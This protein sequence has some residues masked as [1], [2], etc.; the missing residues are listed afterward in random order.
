M[1]LDQL[2]LRKEELPIL[3]KPDC[4]RFTVPI[5][6]ALLRPDVRIDP[7]IAYHV[8]RQA[9]QEYHTELTQYVATMQ[10]EKEKVW[11]K[12]V[13]LK[14]PTVMTDKRG[15][16]T[17]LDGMWEDLVQTGENGFARVLSINRNVGG[18]LFYNSEDRSC[19]HEY[20][21][22]PTVNFTPEKFA[23]YAVLEKNPNIIGVTGNAYSHHN[24]DHYPGAL[25]LRN[26]AIL[27]LNEAMK[28][29][30]GSTE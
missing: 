14:N 24:I 16:Q 30:G 28:S 15:R 7:T 18:T 5:H 29:I 21:S 27:Y 19:T 11:Y 23:A 3:G 26:W 9:A 17:I 25:F 1:K 4:P 6:P 2:L 8:F 12:E 13:F 22:P 20:L 10:D